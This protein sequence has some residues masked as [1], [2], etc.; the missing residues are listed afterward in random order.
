MSRADGLECGIFAR[1]LQQEESA[2]ITT[3]G[4]LPDTDRYHALNLEYLV[5]RD[6]TS[7]QRCSNQTVCS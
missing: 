4:S 1:T 7:A 6:F 3:D 5:E 2:W